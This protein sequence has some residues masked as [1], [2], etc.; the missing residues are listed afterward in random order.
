MQL[1]RGHQGQASVPASLPDWQ[2]WAR[3]AGTLLQD[4]AMHNI[5][6]ACCCWQ[7]IGD[8]SPSCGAFLAPKCKSEN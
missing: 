3:L 4:E 5:D 1:V 8:Q 2:W 7:T 6:C